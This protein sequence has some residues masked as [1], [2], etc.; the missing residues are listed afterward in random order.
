M[1]VRV[2]SPAKKRKG[3][4]KLP[5]F[6]AGE[7]TAVESAVFRT[8][9]EVPPY[10]RGA[11]EIQ[12]GLPPRIAHMLQ[13]SMIPRGGE[14]L[15]DPA[16]IVFQ[17]LYGAPNQVV[18]RTENG[19]GF[20]YCS[21]DLNASPGPIIK[22]IQEDPI[23]HGIAHFFKVLQREEILSPECRMSVGWNPAGEYKVTVVFPDSNFSNR[24]TE[25]LSNVLRLRRYRP[26]D[27]HG[28]DICIQDRDMHDKT[29]LEIILK[30]STNL[31]TLLTQANE[32]YFRNL[33][34][35]RRPRLVRGSVGDVCKSI[36][37][38]V[39]SLRIFTPLAYFVDTNRK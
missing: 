36:L 12:P 29:T 37:T 7:K 30:R 31:T 11:E 5:L 39:T 34:W 18:E 24:N 21:S 1:L 10:V 27:W 25:I 35:K 13:T 20:R 9:D 8:R 26:L 2:R 23:I 6:F 15:A 28:W 17:Y 22:R 38:L 32:V 19:V 4:R 16:N 3:K 14:F 33:R